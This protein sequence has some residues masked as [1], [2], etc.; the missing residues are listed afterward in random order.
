M[1]LLR[2]FYLLFAVILFTT[3]CSRT[4]DRLLQAEQLI[5]TAPD[6]AM[7]IL[8][9]YSYN[10][11]SDKDKAL[12]GLV[13]IQV[14]D[15]KFLSL[16]PDS[17]LNFSMNY[18]QKRP[19]SDYLSTTLLY[20]GRKYKYNL[21]YDKA[22]EYYIK[23]FD[24]LK[25][26]EN[27]LL[28][29]RLNLDLADIHYNQK[30]FGQARDK[31]WKSFVYFK[32]AALQPQA[33]YALLNIGRTYHYS[34]E[35]AKAGKYYLKIKSYSKDSLQ[36]GSLLHEIGQNFYKSKKYDS[37]YYYFHKAIKCPYV[38]N[39][40]SL[41][42]YH[43]ADL[44]FDMNKIDSA[45]YYAE[46]S[47]RG[48]VDLRTR[49]GCYRILVNCK[50]LKGDV[51][52]LKRYM[53]KYQD[54]DDSIRKIDLQTKGSYIET[55]HN[56]QKD[57]EKSR[58]WIWYISAL[59]ILIIVLAILF[60]IRKHRKGIQTIKT[61]E[62]KQL[63]QKKESVQ[64]IVERTKEALH[65]SLKEKRNELTKKIKQNTPEGR[66]EMILQ[67]YDESVH[68]KNK[69]HFKNE[70]DN[71][72]N[73]LYSKLETSYPKLKTKEKQWACLN[74]LDIP[75]DDCIQL[76]DF[77]TES[78]KKMRQRFAQKIGVDTVTNIDAVLKKILYD[79]T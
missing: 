53:S 64:E 41:R 78:F 68:F 25:N 29:A 38:A 35:Y 56:T 51:H 76:L 46:K 17:F 77:N 59:A 72:L 21:M 74:M 11:L 19:E 57:A 45:L 60:Y 48:D 7:A 28:K 2:I 18:Y 37:A 8:N 70:M 79:A 20:I 32:K 14:R 54:C 75:K 67:L 39:N 61:I 22:T 71:T 10:K 65:K 16:E 26:T 3:S 42:Y 55:M 23:A 6:S 24:N 12:Y 13:Y 49:K 58:S 33:F 5:E 50:T 27:N 66:R 31:Y 44:L 52:A 43:L 1:K 34:A 36:E 40:Q 62:E 63:V 30:D 4:N 73:N 9:K 69:Q 47:L 15:K